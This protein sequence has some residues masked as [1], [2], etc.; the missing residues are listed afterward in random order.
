M[1]T[2]STDSSGS[3]SNSRTKLIFFSN[4]FPNDDVKDLFR[5]LRSRSKDRKFRHLAAFLER[6]TVS[7]KAEICKL[8]KTVQDLVPPFQHIL[9]LA[10]HVAFRGSPLGG[11]MESAI[12]CTLQL[13]AL[14]GYHE[15]FVLPFDSSTGS[16]LLSG[17]SVGLF[18]AAAVSASHNLA[19]LS[20]LGTESVRIAFRLGVHV[21]SCSSLLESCDVDGDLKS[22]AYVVTGVSAAEVQKELDSFNNATV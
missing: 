7:I 13:A 3:V 2:P 17:L 19:D 16:L 14:I 15:E 12:L 11:A 1:D 5:R 21:D 10:D 6:C 22:W 9:T 4:E 20:W 8:P 18:A